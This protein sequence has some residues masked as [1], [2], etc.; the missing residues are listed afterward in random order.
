MAYISFCLEEMKD[1]SDRSSNA[2]RERDLVLTTSYASRPLLKYVLSDGF[3]H[4]AHLGLGNAG[5]FKDMETLQMVIFQRAWEWDRMCKLVPSIRSE[6]PWP[7]SEHDFTMYTLVAFASDALFRAFLDRPALT[8]RE[9]TNPLVYA[10]H[11]GKADHAR[12]LILRGANVNHLG[13]VVDELLADNSDMDDVDVDGSNA[14]DSESDISTADYSDEHTAVPIRVAVDHWHAEMLDLLLAQGSTIPDGLLN[15]VLRV[16]P[17]QFPL[18]IIRRLLQTAEFIKWAAAPWDNRRL[19]KA[20]IE[21]EEDYEQINDGD[22]LILAAKGLVQAGFTETLLLVAVEK[23]CIPV[24]RTLLS[25]NIS[26]PTNI[27]SV[28]QPHG[29]SSVRM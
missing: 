13:L 27:P 2:T 9:G 25:I 22:D 19:L 18:Y 8:P 10:A 28:S 24:V 12:A 20:V 16:K 29:R 3:S 6:I 4:L 17:H 26:L 11:F 14:D 1:C 21:H 23:G 5:I 15:R 7:S